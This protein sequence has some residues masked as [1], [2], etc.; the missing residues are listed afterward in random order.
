MSVSKAHSRASTKWNGSRDNIMI[1]PTKDEGACIRAAAEAV[2]QSLQEYILQAVRSRM[3][4]EDTPGGGFGILSP[5]TDT[6]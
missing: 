6:E 3:A 2:G 5:S 1:R 4:S